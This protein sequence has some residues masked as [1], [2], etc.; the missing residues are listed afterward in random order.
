MGGAVVRNKYVWIFGAFPSRPYRRRAFVFGL[1]DGTR[2]SSTSPFSMR[3]DRK[4][5]L[6]NPTRP[7]NPHVTRERET[8]E[9]DTREREIGDIRHE[10]KWN[11]L[12]PF[13]LSL[14]LSLAP[15]CLPLSLT[16][17]SS[18]SDASAWRMVI[19]LDRSKR[20][21]SLG[22]ARTY[23]TCPRELLRVETRFTRAIYIRSERRYV[24]SIK[25]DSLSRLYAIERD[26]C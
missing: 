5:S 13:S 6:P 7:H 22:R 11:S 3:N 9:R 8:Y 19:V 26:P 17:R 15:V 23:R 16:L 20:F 10:P 21:R 2:R 12:P 18:G 25:L 1:Q 24:L 14:S 4:R